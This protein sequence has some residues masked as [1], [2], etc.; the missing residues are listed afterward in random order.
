MKG[1]SKYPNQKTRAFETLFYHLYKFAFGLSLLRGNNVGG[2]A[3][4]VSLVTILQ[5]VN[6]EFGSVASHNHP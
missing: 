2:A 1:S 4:V 3:F 5:P 6:H